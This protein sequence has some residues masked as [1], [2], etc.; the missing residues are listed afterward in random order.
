MRYFVVVPA[1]GSGRR[2]ASATPKQY[3]AV[4]GRALIEVALA[5]FLRDLH[6][7][8]IV[9]AI[10]ADDPHWPAIERRL[11][12]PRVRA[13]TGGAERADSVRLGLAALRNIAAAD[14]WVLV[15][16]AARPCLSRAELASLLGE[17][18]DHEVGGLLAVPLADTLKRARPDQPAQ[19]A[20]TVER[21]HLWRALTPQMFR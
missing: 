1:A 4:A 12:D 18:A 16:D 3:F 10:A 17:L 6:C 13:V 11:N 8:R 15:H 21:A 14:D 7:A 9:V 20:S 19:V 5:P 2:V